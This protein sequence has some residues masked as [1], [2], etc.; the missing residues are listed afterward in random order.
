MTKTRILL[1]DSTDP[2]F[3]LAVEDT[4][5]RSMPADQRVLFLWRN[6]DTVVIGRAQ[7]PWR[8]CK[9]DRMEQDKV[10]LARRQTGGGAVFHDLGN[11]NFTF[12]AGKPEYDKEVSTKI[13][14]A[15][16]QK[17]GIH[18]VANGRNDLVLED[19]QG[20]RKFSGSAY[21]ETLDRGFHHGTLLLSADLNRLADYLNPDLKKLQAKGITSVKSRVINLNTVKADIE[22]QQVCEAI[23]Q[24]YCEHYQQEVEPELIS[25]QSFFDL[26][27]F[28]QKFAQ[29]SSW[30]WNFGQTP[31]FT[32]HMD[33]R[34]S[35]GGVEVYLEVE[36]GTIVQAT[37][38]SDML[39]PY[40]MEQLAL[41]L[42]G[43]TYNKTALEPCLAQLMQELPQYQLSLEE[44]QR[45]FID[46]ID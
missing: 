36:R 33:E 12:M 17:L 40:P 22:H 27:G 11:T 44:F 26:P 32:H 34:F 6:A 9:T 18:G 1:S 5:F 13:V 21:R 28:E 8:E 38:F 14:L 19:E 16:L 42:S 46:Q 2:W 37:I 20:I 35:W 29:Q 3:N 23:M 31:P 24:A 7:N 15:G 39:D 43:L 25:P 10:K 30:D 45:W 41:R 4:I